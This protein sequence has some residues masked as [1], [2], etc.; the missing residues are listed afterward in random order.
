MN[1]PMKLLTELPKFSD[2]SKMPVGCKSW[3]LEA[4]KTCAGAY[5]EDGE[6]VDACEICYARGGFYNMPVVKEARAYNKQNW[7][8]DDWE[9]NM[10]MVIERLPLFRW[11]DSGDCYALKLAKKIRNV[12]M[13][14]PKTKH[15]FP[16]RQH[17]FDKFR[18]V[19]Y[20]ME[21][22]CNVVVRYSSDSITG[23]FVDGLNSSTILPYVDTPTTATI[24]HAYSRGGKCGDC[25]D[26]WDKSIKVIAYPA[27]GRKADKLI[28]MR[29][30]A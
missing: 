10:V 2:T 3:S 4:L 19:L 21:A 11:F 5:G 8:R 20:E 25:R 22:L 28:K 27:H 23:G 7:K 9:D 26:C 30:V 24:C 17:K 14:T 18:G 29:E 16:T 6:I 1:M 15:W 12:M 13:R